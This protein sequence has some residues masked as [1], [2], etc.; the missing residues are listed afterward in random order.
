MAVRRGTEGL[1]R[2]LDARGLKPE[3]RTRA[4][5]LVLVLDSER[6]RKKGRRLRRP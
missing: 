3:A 6:V 5:A 2:A 1:M 4:A